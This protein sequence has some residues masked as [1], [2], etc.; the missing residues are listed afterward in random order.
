MQKGLGS[1]MPCFC[2]IRM[3]IKAACMCTS[4]TSTGRR[5]KVRTICGEACVGHLLACHSS[6]DTARQAGAEAEACIAIATSHC[7]STGRM[8]CA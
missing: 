1:P 8:Q 4:N 5:K 7:Q 2:P 3:C 6:T